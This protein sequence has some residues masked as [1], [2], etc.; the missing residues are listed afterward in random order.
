MTGGV[1][2][3]NRT[4][5]GW[6]G[7]A[8]ALASTLAPPLASSARAQ[9]ANQLCQAAGQGFGCIGGFTSHGMGGVGGG[10]NG[11]DALATG[12]SLGITLF[13]ILN[14]MNQQPAAGAAPAAVTPASTGSYVVARPLAWKPIWSAPAPSALTLEQ[15]TALLG[16][17]RP[18]SGTYTTADPASPS[19]TTDVQTEKTAILDMIRPVS[20]TP[21]SG[22]GVTLDTSAN[23]PQARKTAMLRQMRPL[24]ER[25]GTA[26][27]HSAADQLCAAAGEP[28]GCIHKFVPHGMTGE[29]AS[30]GDV[31]ST[32]QDARAFNAAF[33]ALAALPAI[34]ADATAATPSCAQI[35]GF[36]VNGDQ[37][38][39]Q[40]APCGAAADS[41]EALSAAARVP[42][43][44]A[45]PTT[46]AAGAPLPA[47][48]DHPAATVALLR[49]PVVTR[50]ALDAETKAVAGDAC[51]KLAE[52]ERK[53]VSYRAALQRLQATAPMIATERREWL[54]QQDDAFKGMRKDAADIMINRLGAH[55]DAQ[56]K[57]LDKEARDVLNLRINVNDPD[58][59]RVADIREQYD[60]V[61]RAIVRQRRAID[62]KNKFLVDLVLD[63]TSKAIDLADWIET[64][65]RYEKI[66]DV[67]RLALT[68][69]WIVGPEIAP[70]TGLA[71]SSIELA[72]HSLQAWKS[73][74][75]LATLDRSSDLY[76]RGFA[77][78]E[79]RIGETSKNIRDAQAELTREKRGCAAA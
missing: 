12:L 57:D 64:K 9:A 45:A 78:L 46:G 75:V 25:P 2:M 73:A 48:V 24:G 34:A 50:A 70:L 58:P 19:T 13:S 7:A 4:A 77:T 3:R 79:R 55:Y 38:Q 18:L 63:K 54:K 65:D 71:D 47:A 5:G 61:F 41:D 49:A 72:L 10:M 39:A 67:V 69:K 43:D 15:K 21:T 31:L 14:E 28:A 44:T 62:L 17:M 37:V 74:G 52:L 27:S 66:T 20:P 30:G 59:A 1:M 76:R 60:I 22:A 35:V 68:S 23:S 26:S 53:L 11:A 29:T 6:I 32:A 56:V 40:T 36:T 33:G 51:S 16:R 42:F 8:L